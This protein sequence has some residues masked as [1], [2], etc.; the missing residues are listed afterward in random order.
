MNACLSATLNWW[1]RRPHPNEC[2][3]SDLDGDLYFVSWDESLIPPTMEEPMDYTPAPKVQLDHPV[4]VEVSPALS[5]SSQHTPF[6]CLISFV[7]LFRDIC[8]IGYSG[9]RRSDYV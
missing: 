2:S 1:K 3:G 9:M 5:P 7:Y 6:F 4:S 8:M